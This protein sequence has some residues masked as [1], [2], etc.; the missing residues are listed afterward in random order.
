MLNETEALWGQALELLKATV[1]E[2][3]YKLWFE[4]IRALDITDA[5][6]VV[7]AVPHDF[8]R[9]WIESNYQDKIND[10]LFKLT[11]APLR[12]SLIV[13]PTISSS[14]NDDSVEHTPEPSPDSEDSFSGIP[15]VEVMDRPSRAAAQ[16][17]QAGVTKY[18]F[19]TFII[20][21]SNE[22]A[23]HAAM[24]V[25]ERPGQS[26]NPLF[27]YGGSGLG[28]THL[29]HAVENYIN[30]NLPHLKVLYTP[31]IDF[32]N[33]FVQSTSLRQ[34]NSRSM[35]EFHE[36]YR[37]V[38]VLLMDDLQTIEGKSGSEDAF[39]NIFNEMVSKG[40]QIVM[41]ADRPPRDL[42][43]DDRY[44][45][46]FKQGLEADVHPPTYEMRL[47]ILHG[48]VRYSRLN[49]SDDILKYLAEVSTANIREIEGAVNRIQAWMGLR[50]TTEFNDIGIVKEILKDFFPEHST[51]TI[52]IKTIQREVCRHYNLTAAEL[53]SNKRSHDIVYPRQVAMYLARTLTD[54]SLPKIGEKFGGRD[55]TTV[56]HAEGKIKKEMKARPEVFDQIQHLTTLIRQN[57]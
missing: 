42:K 24:A 11:G 49:I 36:R 22:F 23:R 50:K 53:I 32:V 52:D 12:A 10:A 39:F 20:G 27:I 43:M 28:K 1:E 2:R 47:A 45:S 19:D 57:S 9:N 33:H 5:G 8:S 46:R 55:H 21:D 26:Y 7:L 44:K 6:E 14:S 25:A 34:K 16:N 41:A 13:D 4:P 30:E 56:M 40:K 17:A 18:T 37:K 51:K 15:V 31:T 48:Y 35:D 3:S 54:L 29:L 38:D